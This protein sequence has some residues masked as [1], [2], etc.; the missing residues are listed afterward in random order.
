MEYSETAGN[1][2]KYVNSI[3]VFGFDYQ[4]IVL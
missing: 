3:I 1:S 4:G 2:S